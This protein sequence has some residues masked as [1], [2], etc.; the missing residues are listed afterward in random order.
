MPA[1]HEAGLQN[2][3][4]REEAVPPSPQLAQAEGAEARQAGGRVESVAGL[5]SIIAPDGR[6]RAAHPGDVILPHERIETGVEGRIG[7]SLGDGTTFS[8]GEGS[9]AAIDDYSPDTATA[10]SDFSVLRGTFAFVSGTIAKVHPEAVHI[11]TPV[12]TVGIRG[13]AVAIK[14]DPDSGATALGLMV[15]RGDHVGEVSVTNAAGTTVINQGYQGVTVSSSTSLPSQP[16]TLTAAQFG[17][18]FGQ[19]INSLPHYEQSLPDTFRNEIQHPADPQHGPEQPGNGKEG[20][21]QDHHPTDITALAKATEPTPPPALDLATFKLQLPANSAQG[22][23]FTALAKDAPIQV[24]E[25]ISYRTNPQTG[26]VESVH[27]AAERY[28]VAGSVIDGYIKNATVFADANGNGVLDAGE[29]WTTTDDAGHFA[30]TNG[31]GAIVVVGGTDVSTGLA[32]Q[33]TLKAAAGSS[34]VTPLTTMVQSLV[35]SNPSQSLQAAEAAVKQGLGLSGSVD[36]ASFDPVQAALSGDAQAAATAKAV[37]AAAVMVQNTV[38]QA[39][40]VLQGAGAAQGDAVAAVFAKLAAKV[41][42]G[43]DITQSQTLHDVIVDSAAAQGQAVDITK[44]AAVANSVAQVIGEANTQMHQTA[45]SGG[46]GLAFLTQVAQI[47]NVAQGSAATAISQAAQTGTAGAATSLVTNYTGNALTTAVAQAGGNIGD[48][49]GGTAPST[50]IDQVLAVSADNHTLAGSTGNDTLTGDAGNDV[51]MGGAGTDTLIGNGGNDSLYGGAGDDLMTVGDGSSYVFGGDGNDRVVLGAGTHYVDGGAGTDTAEVSGTRSHYELRYTGSG[52]VVRDMTVQGSVA[53]LVN[54]ENLAFSDGTIALTH[55]AAPQAG[56]AA[57]QVNQGGSVIIHP[58]DAASDPDNN[59]LTLAGIGAAAHGTLTDLG[60]GTVRYTPT[61]QYYGADSFTYQ[62]SDS[63]GG[64]SAGVITITVNHVNQSPQAAAA[65]YTTAW[66]APVSGALPGSDGD[67]A[68]LTYSILANG[69]HGQAVVTDPTTGAFT[70]TPSNRSAG[71]D[72]FT[73]QVSDGSLTASGTIS[74]STTAVTVNGSGQG[75]SISVG[76][77]STVVNAYGGDD[78][79]NVTDRALADATIDG[80]AGQDTVALPAYNPGEAPNRDFVSGSYQLDANGSYVYSLTHADGGTLTLTNVEF[81][82]LGDKTYKLA[83]SPHALID[84]VYSDGEYVYPGWYNDIGAIWS[85]D[86]GKVFMLSSPGQ[87][88]YVYPRIYSLGD[89]VVYG[90]TGND[91]IIDNIAN[92]TI[93]AGSGDDSIVIGF[94]SNDSVDAGSGDDTVSIVGLVFQHSG[95]IDGGAGTDT[96]DLTRLP[97]DWMANVAINLATS[98]EFVGFENITAPWQGYNDDSFYTFSN[99]VFT[100]TAGD[101]VISGGNTIFGGAGNDTLAYADT[102]LGGTGD[103]TLTTG[104]HDSVVDGGA[105]ADLVHLEGDTT[106]IDTVIERVGSGGTTLAEADVVTGFVAGQDVVALADGLLFSDLAITQGTGAYRADTVI[107]TASGEY[108]ARLVGVQASTLDSSSFMRWASPLLAG[109]DVTFGNLSIVQGTGAFANDT[110]ISYAPTGEFLTRLVGV[111]ADT[112]TQFTLLDW[113]TSP[114]AVSGSGTVSGS[115]LGDTITVT[116]TDTAVRA[117][118]GDDTIA[119]GSRA[120]DATIDGGA[121]QDTVTLPAYN[122]GEAPA[123]DFVSGSYQLDANGT[124]VYSLTHAD[125]GTLTLTNVEFLKLGDKTYK[126]ATSPHARIDN[127]YSDG[128]YVY[129]GWYNDIG[130]IWSADTGKVFMLSSPGQDA[131]VYP[132]IY[133]LGDTVVYGGAGNDH[134]IDN[135]ANNTIFAGAGD[136]SIVI[137]FGS[138]DSVDAGSGDDTVSVVG[139]VFQHS[140]TID[141]GAGTDTLDLTRLPRDWMANVAINL[142]TSTEFVGFENIAAPWQGYNDDSFYTFSN[143]VFTGTAGDNAISGGNTIFGG[144]G[145]DTLAYADTI[146]GG[147]GDDTITTGYHDS[148]VDGGAGADRIHLEGNATHIDTVFERVGSGGATLAEAD[149]VTG[150]VAGQD[151]VALADGLLFSD[152]A[153]TQGTGAYGADTIIATAS[154]E[155]LARLVGVQASSLGYSTFVASQASTAGNIAPVAGAMTT[156]SLDEDGVSAGITLSGTASQGQTIIQYSITA[157]PTHGTLF[158]DS[159]GNGS[160]DAGEA[161]SAGTHISA[162]DVANGRLHYQGTALYAGFDSF[163]YGAIDSLGT[164]SINTST[165]QLRITPV[166]HA[167]QVAAVTWA[168]NENTTGSGAL[169]ATD[170]ESDTLTYT[171]VD[172]PQHGSVTLDALHPGVFT[173]TPDGSYFGQD[174]FTYKANDGT[175]DSATVAAVS[176]SVT[177]V[178]NAPTASQ[179]I[180]TTDEGVDLIGGHLTAGNVVAGHTLAYTVDTAPSKGTLTYDQTT[181][182]FSYHPFATVNGADAFTYH[183]TDLTTQLSSA[184]AAIAITVT[185]VDTAP[186]VSSGALVVVENTAATTYLMAMDPDGHALTYSIPDGLGPAHGTI[187]N[188]DPATGHFTY[189]PDADYYGADQFTFRATDAAE[190]LYSEAGVSVYVFGTKPIAADDSVYAMEGTPLTLMS[191]KLAAND[192]DPYGDLLHVSAVGNAAHGTVALDAHNNVLFTPEDGFIGTA[193]FD[194]TVA[195]SHGGQDTA[196]VTVTVLAPT[197]DANGDHASGGGGLL[198]Y[199]TSGNDTVSFAGGAI[200]GI[201]GNGGTDTWQFTGAGLNFSLTQ[202]NQTEFYG[203]VTGVSRVDLAANGNNTLVMNK[204]DV[205]GMGPGGSNALL[206]GTAF[207][208]HANAV[209]VTGDATDH[210]TLGDAWTNLT[211]TAS[212]EIVLAGGPGGSFSVY[213]SSNHD[214]LIVVDDRVHVTHA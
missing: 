87:D 52:V 23:L 188:L 69:A 151:V 165:V 26:A 138:N 18:Q 44:V 195:D 42:A 48:V 37:L 46:D 129:P 140:G 24:G 133:S 179:Q 14:V 190:G 54:V 58:L 17:Q 110:M 84:N 130:A 89:T 202:A 143:A 60:D 155:Y 30:L 153:I 25:M 68:N 45:T 171:V 75:D 16:F 96:L 182:A 162:T 76:G 100:G 159:N 35:E 109:H 211:P 205:A 102:I 79:V 178:P 203:A 118:G 115:Q 152:L 9:L 172:G 177:Y 111:Q 184:Q 12:A 11:K 43:Q 62:V 150:F 70:Y 200:A 65:S 53:T 127:V 82:K 80:G 125:G 154:G 212:Q 207:A 22:A 197:T 41:A 81:L 144:A 13:T 98:T 120:W 208:G 122:P 95:T 145:N 105:G 83:T 163:R 40:S 169:A 104:Y 157:L 85:A 32:H 146:L 66:N 61:G 141:G 148:V 161:V 149:V 134:I 47:A 117:H 158:V 187:T 97:R 29:V 50:P 214:A 19:A 114:L 74:L 93:F 49:T 107:T 94:G 5:V 193:S 156:V 119:V 132:R 209:V 33:G 124:Y 206:T 91:H 57:A 180:L 63:L 99:A 189:T 210:L 164:P 196:T 142:A 128:E 201:H 39:S 103:D 56:T 86:T 21:L 176:I 51:L 167:P 4:A 77:G 59:A 204:F 192:A 126:L 108:L 113:L 168:T 90:G 173:Y 186:V 194:Y 101:N 181:G 7:V 175:A 71:T 131:Y 137:G 1:Q 106:H 6:S 166:N 27:T 198:A 31:I 183:V 34:V 139:L 73:Y 191:R 121:G 15:E 199:G 28:S 78:I 170:A 160:L 116:G 10:I 3:D 88:A 123:R 112:V 147:T 136:D 36:L 2:S 213:E 185:P 38:V 72:S 92:N 64:V 8:L 174:S 67:S 55:N 135:I 20:L